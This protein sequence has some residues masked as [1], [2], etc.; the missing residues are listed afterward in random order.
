MKRWMKLQDKKGIGPELITVV[1]IFH[2]KTALSTFLQWYS[3]SAIWLIEIEQNTHFNFLYNKTFKKIWKTF[4]V[5]ALL[6]SVRYQ[7][8]YQSRSCYPFMHVNT[9]EI[10]GYLLYFK[11][12]EY[13]VPIFVS[14][15][16]V[17][18]S[19]LEPN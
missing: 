17:I 16:I 3:R 10:S 12:T 13:F 2:K 1:Y 6:H 8:I 11:C 19:S 18:H 15:L 7:T 5:I 4:N 14:K 9:L